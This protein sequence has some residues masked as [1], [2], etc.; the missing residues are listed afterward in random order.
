MNQERL[1][2]IQ[3]T[4]AAGP[5]AANWDSLQNYQISDYSVAIRSLGSG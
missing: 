5:F 1:A 4:I 3:Q 2:N